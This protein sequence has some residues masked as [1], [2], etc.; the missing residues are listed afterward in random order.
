MS[1]RVRCRSCR[2]AFL[3][4]DARRAA[5]PKCGARVDPSLPASAAA[6][7]V[8][9]PADA[10]RPRRSGRRR[11]LAALAFLTV[12]GVALIAA[13]PALKR[14]W[15]P[16]PP[17]PVEFVAN[18]YLQALVKGDAEEAGKIG[19]VEIPP[20][21]RS[22]REVHRDT[23]RNRRVQGSFAPITAFHGK[24]N[25]TYTWDPESGRFVP[26]NALGAAAETLDALH[27]AKTKAEAEKT[28]EKIKSGN[29]E[30]IFDGAESLAKSMAALSEGALSPKKLIP[31]YKHL[32]DDAKPPLPPTER[33]LALH[34]AD[35]RETWER[36]LKRPFLTLKSDDPYIFDR[37]EVTA[38]VVD[39]LGSS[40]APPT[41]MRLT[42]TRFR[43]GLVDTK[44][45][46]TSTRRGNAPDPAAQPPTPQPAPTPSPGSSPGAK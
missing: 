31:T 30:D 1:Q 45:R 22:F 36:L 39:S 37:T 43:L 2:T 19:T 4:D 44:W 11:A 46:V 3:V 10:D 21:I 41:P 23:T 32:I 33:E 13:W 42:L 24:I 26:K 35:N 34:Y 9:V 6:G 14:W 5:C 15:H 18:A 28:A 12:A 17:D 25:A 38:L 27:D 29:P 40:G 16:V 20:A 8:F 7:N